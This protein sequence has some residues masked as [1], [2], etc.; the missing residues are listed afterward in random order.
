MKIEN[1][2]ES[3]S[4]EKRPVVVK[5]HHIMPESFTLDGFQCRNVRRKQ[6]MDDLETELWNISQS[7]VIRHED[8][9][10]LS[11]LATRDQ[12]LRI[13][14][15]F[16]VEEVYLCQNLSVIQELNQWNRQ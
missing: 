9:G 8:A 2:L 1:W 3:S 10:A 16:Y 15:L 6:A 5:M 4:T 12:V 13:Q 11:L 7:K 14:S